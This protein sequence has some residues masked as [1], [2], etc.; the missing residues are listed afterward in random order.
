MRMI[1][2]KKSF[3][4][5]LIGF[6]LIAGCKSKYGK[7]AEINAP[8]WVFDSNIVAKNADEISAVGM[9][10][11][12]QS[13]LRIQWMQAEMDA[14][15]KIATQLLVEVSKISKDAIRQTKVAGVEDVQKIFSQASQEIVRDLPL[16]GVKKTHLWQDPKTDILYIRMVL[17]SKEVNDHLKDSM[18][19]YDKRLQQSGLGFSKAESKKL[20][21]DID[22]GIDLR[23]KDDV[24]NANDSSA[25]IT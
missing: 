22:K 23:F 21:S 20:V 8:E 4:F 11:V 1:F 9:S 16:S 12:T 6:F 25:D 10:D 24:V 2:N 17:K 7:L 5:I 18:I 3:L 19:L 14:R 15:T 13:G